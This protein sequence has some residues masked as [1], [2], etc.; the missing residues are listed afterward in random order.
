MRHLLRCTWMQYH[1]LY[2][3]RL[4]CWRSCRRFQLHQLSPIRI[5]STRQQHHF[6]CTSLYQ[7][8]NSMWYNSRRIHR[9]FIMQYHC[10]WM[11]LLRSYRSTKY[12][13]LCQLHSTFRSCWC[14]WCY[15]ICAGL[16]CNSDKFFS[17]DVC[18]RFPFVCKCF[19]FGQVGVSFGYEYFNWEQEVCCWCVCDDV[20][21]FAGSCYLPY[22]SLYVG[23][24]AKVVYSLSFPSF[25]NQV[26]V[27]PL[28]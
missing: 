10:M 12:H 23:S 8:L 11:R 5:A 3:R 19:R 18:E 25:L 22:F 1:R 16:W 26:I 6:I 17:F 27:Y 13:Y 14:R 4:Q 28:G 24:V 2:L 15:W 7:L 9:Y 21:Y 20:L